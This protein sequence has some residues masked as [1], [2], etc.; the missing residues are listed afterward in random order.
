MTGQWW[1]KPWTLVNG[2]TPMSP[3]C[4]NCWLADFTYRHSTNPL[5]KDQFKGLTALVNDTPTFNTTVRMREDRLDLPLS[6]R[7]PTVFAVWS[8][9]FHEDVTSM[10][11]FKALETMRISWRHTFIVLT[12]RPT[13]MVEKMAAIKDSLA[14]KNEVLIY[15]K[16]GVLKTLPAFSN[17]YFGVT[18]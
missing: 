3:A 4:D 16:P 17:V 13:R 5:M 1:H 18:V 12:K 14:A 9:L 7:K 10:F 8:D 15:E 6:T 11:I 2:C